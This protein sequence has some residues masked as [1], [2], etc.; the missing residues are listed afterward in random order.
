[1]YIEKC[2]KLS[3]HSN[4]SSGALLY[5]DGE[6]RYGGIHVPG[7]QLQRKAVAGLADCSSKPLVQLCLL[8]NTKE[9]SLEICW[10]LLLQVVFKEVTERDFKAGQ[11]LSLMVTGGEKQVGEYFFFGNT[12]NMSSQVEDPD[13]D[14]EILNQGEST[15]F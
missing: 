2:F 5:I 14:K 6:N 11:E 10:K 4:L 3:K 9:F 13:L 7:L 12:E 15:A 1:M 8:T